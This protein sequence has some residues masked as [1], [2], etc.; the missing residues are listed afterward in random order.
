ML[1]EVL[2]SFTSLKVEIPQCQHAPLQSKALHLKP[3]FSKGTEVLAGKVIYL[4]Y[5]K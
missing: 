3:Y 1:E 2:R 5:E 4:K